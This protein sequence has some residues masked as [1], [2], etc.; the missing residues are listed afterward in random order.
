M[1]TLKAF[2]AIKKFGLVEDPKTNPKI[3]A[4]KDKWKK[5]PNINWIYTDKERRKAYRDGRKEQK[6]AYD[7]AYRLR[8]KQEALGEI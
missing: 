3:Q 1:A 6:L 2:V 5:D 8:K 7:I 4:L